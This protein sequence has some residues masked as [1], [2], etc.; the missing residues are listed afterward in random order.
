ME[1]DAFISYASEDKKEIAEPLAKALKSEGLKIWYDDFSL[2][3]GDSLRESIDKGL[4]KSRYGIVILSHTFFSKKWP[5]NELNALF[6]REVNGVKVILP[7][8]HNVTQED[9][10][11][12]SP[13]LADRYA[14]KTSDGLEKVVEKIKEVI[15][16]PKPT[17]KPTMISNSYNVITNELV[18]NGEVVSRG[19]LFIYENRTYMPLELISLALGIPS[20]NVFWNEKTKTVTLM[21]R[22]RVVNLM[23]GS[24]VMTINGTQVNIEHLPIIIKNGVIMINPKDAADALGVW[25][26]FDP[27]SNTLHFTYYNS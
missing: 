20:D 24:K 13:I 18:V 1:L 9:V 25:F 14:V 19:F 11:Q 3:L 16:P 26:N 2:S 21:K 5:Q 22:D 7:V 23:L 4:S 8:W 17:T 6:Y 12:Y 15:K 27:G 10:A